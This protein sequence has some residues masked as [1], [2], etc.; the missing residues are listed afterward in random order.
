MLE[1]VAAYIDVVRSREVLE[2]SINNERVLGEQLEATVARFELGETTKTDV[3]QSRSRLATAKSDRINAEGQVTAA[4][5]EF[6]RV[7]VV[8]P[9]LNMQLPPSLPNVPDSLDLVIE[10]ALQNNPSLR[11]G[12]FNTDVA[13]ANVDVAFS[14]ILPTVSLN[15]NMSRSEG[16]GVGRFANVETESVTLNVTVPIYQTGSQHSA[17]RQAKKNARTTKYQLKQ[18][19]NDIVDAA[20]DAW[21]RYTTTTASIDARKASV[22]AAELALEGVREEQKIGSR[23]ILEVLDAEQELFRAR[24]E[25][26][27]AERDRVLA[28]Y[29]IHAAMG[30]LTARDLELQ[31]DTYDPSTHFR[32]VKYKF[33]GF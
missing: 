6:K 1:A 25:L 16:G 23:T 11:A 32:E 29:N 27:S 20:I 18:Q 15:G 12:K 5:S 22:D 30:T 26:V 2:L 14:E 33:V 9:P 7:F 4:E 8:A 24:V 28:L 21:Q 10:A 3:A 31:V 17:I 13:D 19:H